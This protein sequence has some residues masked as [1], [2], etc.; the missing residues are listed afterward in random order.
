SGSLAAPNGLYLQSL[1]LGLLSSLLAIGLVLIYRAN[2]IIN[3]AQ[4]ALGSMA[5]TLANELF[6]RFSV[7]YVISLIT[8]VV[9][10]VLVALI[11]EFA[12]I[13]RFAKAPRMILTVATIGIFEILS[14]V[15]FLP[16]LLNSGDTTKTH[17]TGAF[18]SPFTAHFNLGP[19]AFTAD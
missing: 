2:R 5:A 9:A 14:L 13:R 19:V 1:I 12:F 16:D 6:A 10:G 11:V 17:A 4:G 7:P 18:R 8:G 3:F 15:E